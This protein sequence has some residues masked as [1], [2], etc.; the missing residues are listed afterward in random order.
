MLTG[1]GCPPPPPPPDPQT[2][3][4]ARESQTIA[5]LKQQVISL[6]K[7]LADAR[8][9]SEAVAKLTE[10]I[11]E[12][13]AD[14]ARLKKEKARV[15][16]AQNL[17]EKEF[18]V[19]KV[20]LG[21]LT[22]AVNLDEDPGDDGIQV[23]LYLLDQSGDPIKR[24]GSVRLELYDLSRESRIIID[25]WE[26]GPDELAKF[27]SQFL[28]VY[29]FRLN[30]HGPCPSSGHYV[31]RGVFIDRHGR[32]FKSFRDVEITPPPVKKPD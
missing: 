24:A 12:L 15:L 28:S 23:Y 30:W 6:E 16:E 2:A 22:S 4:T 20:A 31:L 11:E 32:E 21:V 26:L 10:E 27:W 3:E 1:A 8:K 19:T 14:V 18:V 29:S 17:S 7:A 25:Q 5:R 13:K 9:E